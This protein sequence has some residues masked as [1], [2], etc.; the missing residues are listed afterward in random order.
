[1]NLDDGRILAV[2]ATLGMAAAGAMRRAASSV[3]TDDTRR[4]LD[5]VKDRALGFKDA[6]ADL[7]LEAPRKG[8]ED[9]EAYMDGWKQGWKLLSGGEWE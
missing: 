7:R 8:Y 9:N 1:M 2:L 3:S 5:R 4:R 6:A